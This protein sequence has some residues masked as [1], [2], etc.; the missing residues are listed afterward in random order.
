MAPSTRPAALA[1]AALTL[2][3]A[4]APAAAAAAAAAPSAAPPPMALAGGAA[5]RTGEL[6]P[7]PGETTNKGGMSAAT[8]TINFATATED[9]AK[10]AAAAVAGLDEGAATAEG[11]AAGALRASKDITAPRARPPP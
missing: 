4:L 7:L 11:A 2:A 8:S 3:L 5:A 1:L 10:C 9:A 6:A